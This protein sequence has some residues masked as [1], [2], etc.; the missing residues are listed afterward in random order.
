M[1]LQGPLWKFALDFYAKPGVAMALLTLQDEADVD[2]IQVLLT[3]Y[4]YKTRGHALSA[5][6]LADAA[7][8]MD[9]WRE[10][11][12]L[13][14]RRVRKSLRSAE[15][16]PDKEKLRQDVKK[17]ELLAEQIQIAMAER[18]LNGRHTSA[19]L[20]LKAGI[21]VLVGHSGRDHL[22]QPCLMA[23]IDEI[24]KAASFPSS[25]E[26]RDA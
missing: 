24:A 8:E 9:E 14:L 7:S 12:V 22:N 23:A 13:P 19:G 5:D 20:Q 21:S 3:T 1:Q 4:T 6:D 10:V 26:D 15:S 16:R 11:V 2:V 17:A 25:G 18:W